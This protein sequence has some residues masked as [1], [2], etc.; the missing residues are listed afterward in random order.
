MCISNTHISAKHRDLGRVTFQQVAAS[1]SS[2]VFRGYRQIT[3][4][5]HMMQRTIDR[6]RRGR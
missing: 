4:D 3:I 5:L 6:R 2:G 1:G